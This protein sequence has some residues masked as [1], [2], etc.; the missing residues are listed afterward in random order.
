MSNIKTGLFLQIKT[1]FINGTNEDADVILITKS[2]D[3]YGYGHNLNGR[4]G[5]GTEKPVSN[6][7]IIP[8][9]CGKSVKKVVFSPSFVGF[10]TETM[11][12]YT[13]G[14]KIYGDIGRSR[15]DP[16]YYKPWKIDLGAKLVVDIKSCSFGICLLTITHELYY[17]TLRCGTFINTVGEST[18]LLNFNE[19]KIIDFCCCSNNGLALTDTGKV[20]SYGITKA[21]LEMELSETPRL[22]QL[23]DNDFVKSISCGYDHSLLL[24][25]D[26]KM[27]LSGFNRF[28]Q[29]GLGYI[30]I[31]YIELIELNMKAV[32]IFA[33][34]NISMALNA[35]N[36]IMVWGNLRKGIVEKPLET[37]FASFQEAINAHSKDTFLYKP[38]SA[39]CAVRKKVSRV[40]N[41]ILKAFNDQTFSDLKFKVKRK[42][43]ENFDYIYVHKWFIVQTCEYFEKMFANE[44]IESRNNEVLINGYSYEAYYQ[45]I[46]CLYTDLVF[47]EDMELLLE[48]LRICDEYLIDDIKA[49]LFSRIIPLIKI[50]N[51]C[52]VYSASVKYP[53]LKNMQEFA[54][55]FMSKNMKF[56]TET[57][58]F[59]KMDG[60][61][62]KSFIFKFFKDR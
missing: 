58:D 51:V 39:K 24:T 44:W 49:K 2:D 8:E 35:S 30:N 15:L 10:L 61:C 56:V 19:A 50:E 43:S 59:K 21:G 17:F 1:I 23:A 32:E 53:F 26:Q 28:G 5:L 47:T 20:F 45:F 6:P 60:N 3:V 29:L 38:I 33:F 46:R 18:I 12:V 13:F 57:E 40:M 48:M 14:L 54:F 7:T 4:L 42:N 27:Y 31:Y 36:R 62:A 16:S 41:T 22:L 52:S 11:D 55:E 34:H 9:L 37:D 25:T